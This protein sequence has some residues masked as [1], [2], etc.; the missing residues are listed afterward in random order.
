MG[1]RVS[2]VLITILVDCR[3]TCRE[4]CWSTLV[5]CVGRCIDQHVNQNVGWYTSQYTSRHSNDTSLRVVNFWW[6]I[7]WLLEVHWLTVVYHKFTYLFQAHL[8]GW[9]PYLRGGGGLFN[10]EKTMVSVLLKDLEYKVSKG[11]RL[12][13]QGSKTNQN[14]QLV[15]KLS[16]ISP[17]KVKQSWLI[18]T[19]YYY[20]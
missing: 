10:L 11:W 13:S 20:Y 4:I 15:N 9:G 17:L 8:M 18:N 2:Q 19:F 5:R 16:S 7:S 3:L 1:R 12:C 14:F 6:N